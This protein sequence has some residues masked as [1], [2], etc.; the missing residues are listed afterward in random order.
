MILALSP[1][2]V[3]STAFV[4][5]CKGNVFLSTDIF[6]EADNLIGKDYSCFYHSD[7][8]YTGEDF[9]EIFLITFVKKIVPNT[10]LKNVNKLII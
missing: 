4:S 7:D 10:T 8:Y 3:I 5:L 2:A 1:G 9:G 6:V